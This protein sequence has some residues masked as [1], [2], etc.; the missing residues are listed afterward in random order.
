MGKG[1]KKRTN[2]TRSAHNNTAN[3][4][5]LPNNT[6]A[7]V[8]VPNKAMDNIVTREESVHLTIHHD[9]TTNK[10]ITNSINDN[11]MVNN[12]QTDNTKTSN[13][14]QE[15]VHFIS[16]MLSSTPASSFDVP[17]NHTVPTNVTDNDIHQ[18]SINSNTFHDIDESPAQTGNDVF[19]PLPSHN[20]STTVSSLNSTTQLSTQSSDDSIP[21]VTVQPTKQSSIERQTAIYNSAIV[22]AIESDHSLARTSPVI[23]STP[24]AVFG[25]SLKHQRILATLIL[26]SVNGSSCLYISKYILSLIL[27]NKSNNISVLRGPAPHRLLLV[28][29]TLIVY[30]FT[31][32]FYAKI[33]GISDR[34]QAI[35][36]RLYGWVYY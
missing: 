33:L 8:L 12:S 10:I 11:P 20:G 25:L 13:A 18:Q 6:P 14:H 36:Q 7:D 21:P 4:H 2:S 16:E 29:I 9:E 35:V 24:F 30:P 23:T 1:R 5:T 3:T 22:G 27:A 31:L 32:T 19:S 28:L 26:F 34:A 17:L 15:P